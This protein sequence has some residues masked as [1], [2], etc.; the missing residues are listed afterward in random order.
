MILVTGATGRAGSSVIEALPHD[1]YVRASFRRR[2]RQARDNV[3]WVPFSFDDE[4]SFAGAL[5]GVGAVFLMRPPQ[6]ASAKAFKP[7]LA[8]LEQHKIRR[9]VLMTVRG[10]D[11]NTLLPHHGLDISKPTGAERGRQSQAVVGSGALG[12]IP[13]RAGW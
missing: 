11:S 10:A 1:M 9:V 3:E 12:C 5:Q 7:F 4:R 2:A 13:C 8:A 6:M